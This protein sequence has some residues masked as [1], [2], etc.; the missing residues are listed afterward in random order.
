M[1]KGHPSIYTRLPL[2]VFVFFLF[3]YLF[4]ARGQARGLDE[5]VMFTTM[6]NAWQNQTLAIDELEPLHRQVKIG[7]YGA[8]NHL[9]S[10]LPPGN[11]VPYEQTLFTVHNSMLALQLREVFNRQPGEI[12]AFMLRI[13]LLI[14][15]PK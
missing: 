7:D 9:Y 8:G 15:S 4:T 14:F 13:L 1:N 6:R 2:L 12:D 5:T 3:F 11:I 10:K